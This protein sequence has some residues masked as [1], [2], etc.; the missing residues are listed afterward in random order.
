VASLGTTRDQFLPSLGKL[1]ALASD[2]RSEVET[3]CGP[4]K[5]SMLWGPL[6]EGAEMHRGVA[7]VA[8]AVEARDMEQLL[9]LVDR[10]RDT[11]RPAAVALGAELD[12]KAS[13]CWASATAWTD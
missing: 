2:L 9:S 6:V 7:V 1:Q 5:R 11:L 8:A 3:V 13:W 12:K 4:P 10:V